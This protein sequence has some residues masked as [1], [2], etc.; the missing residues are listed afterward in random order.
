MALRPDKDIKLFSVIKDLSDLGLLIVG[1]QKLHISSVANI[2]TNIYE[3]KS[4]V[5]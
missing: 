5:Q 4:I 3:Q 1:P 2:I